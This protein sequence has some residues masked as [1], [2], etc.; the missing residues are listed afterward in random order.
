M[1]YK[2]SILIIIVFIAGLFIAANFSTP[3]KNL[4]MTGGKLSPCPD[5]PNCVSSQAS[6]KEHGIMPIK[7][8]GTNSQVIKKL[9]SCIRKMGGSIVSSNGPYLHAEFKSRFFHFVD[10]LECVYNEVEET[11]EIRSASRLGYSDLGVNRKR[12]EELRTLFENN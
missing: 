12:V 10:D 4:G 8:R 3:P 11:I 9:E 1:I 5:S 2:L 7:A 6:S